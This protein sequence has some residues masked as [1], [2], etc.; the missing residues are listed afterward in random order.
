MSKKKE[1]KEQKQEQ[2]I[3]MVI[4]LILD[5]S[6]SMGCQRQQTISAVNEYVQEQR[7]KSRKDVLFSL[8]KFNT[9][10][11]IVHNAV[12]IEEVPD[13]ALDTYTPGGMTALY[14]AIG[15]SIATIETKIKE[16]D[17]TPGILCVVFTDGH[18]NASKEFGGAAGLTQIRDLIK[19]REEGD[20]WTFVFLGCTMDAW[21]QSANM[22]FSAGSTQKYDQSNTK[23]TL[24]E[25][26]ARTATYTDAIRSGDK[27]KVR[28][29]RTKGFYSDAN[30]PAQQIDMSDGA[31]SADEKKEATAGTPDSK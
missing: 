16:L 9:D 5:E 7:V 13:L 18:E 29:I 27:S 24:K 1:Q 3:E 28:N 11:T 14:D 8:T 10:A 6:S 15:Q 26:S 12:P 22:G 31:E 21:D 17:I 25:A 19:T 4:N 23:G 2:Q 30:A 20:D